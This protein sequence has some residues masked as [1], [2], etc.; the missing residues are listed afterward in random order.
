[1]ETTLTLKIPF[2]PFEAL[3]GKTKRAREGLTVFLR[4]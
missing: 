1:M 2:W 4:N 3:F